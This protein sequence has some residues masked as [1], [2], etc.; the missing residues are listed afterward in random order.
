MLILGAFI[1]SAG[2]ITFSWN[3]KKNWRMRI[4]SAPYFSKFFGG[5]NKIYWTN[6]TKKKKFPLKINMERRNKISTKIETRFWQSER[7]KF[8]EGFLRLQVELL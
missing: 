4:L 8:S 6:V 7:N 3:K 5:K 2:K 1:F